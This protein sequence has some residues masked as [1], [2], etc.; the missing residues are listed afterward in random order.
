MG[1]RGFEVVVPSSCRRGAVVVPS[2]CRRPA[3]VVVPREVQ[4]RCISSASS[5]RSHR[6]V[7]TKTFPPK[8]FHRNVATGAP[9]LCRRRRAVVV[10]ASS[11]SAAPTARLPP[12][13]PQHES[14]P[15]V[16][17]STSPPRVALSTSPPRVALS[18]SVVPRRRAVPLRCRG[19]G[20][21]VVAPSSWCRRR[22]VP[23]L[24]RR[25]RAVVS[26]SCRR[27][28]AVVVAAPRGFGVARLWGSNW[29][30]IWGNAALG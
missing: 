10:V 18:T 14:S 19:R 27:R 17:L 21:V 4:L 22:A 29:G 8:S 1:Q 20:A 26:P 23:S 3:V 16:A 24:C 11:S 2:W 13:L 30:N 28:R 9:S 5:T 12:W 7:S 15:R 25:R 6:N